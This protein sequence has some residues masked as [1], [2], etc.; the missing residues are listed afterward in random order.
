MKSMICAQSIICRSLD[1][2]SV[3]E[4]IRFI[5]LLLYRISDLN[6][7]KSGNVSRETL[8]F[9]RTEYCNVFELSSYMLNRLSLRCDNKIYTAAGV[10]P[11][12]LSAWPIVVGLILLNLD[13][14]SFER[15]LNTS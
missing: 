8:R 10:I 13:F 1:I 7:S 6:S 15:P 3:L 9:S 14:T 11:S 4:L 2:A 5:F 12:I